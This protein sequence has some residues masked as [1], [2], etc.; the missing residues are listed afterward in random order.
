MKNGIG[1]KSLINC[2]PQRKIKSSNKKCLHQASNTN[3]KVL[4]L[5]FFAPFSWSGK[6]LSTELEI[7]RGSVPGNFNLRFKSADFSSDSES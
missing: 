2:V 7:T 4:K 3:E 6:K 1:E 5:H